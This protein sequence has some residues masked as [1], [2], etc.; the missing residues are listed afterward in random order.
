MPEPTGKS[1]RRPAGKALTTRRLLELF[2]DPADMVGSLRSQADPWLNIW[3]PCLLFPQAIGG[4]CFIGRPEGL[5]VVAGL[6]VMLL[7]VGYIHRHAPLSR[8]IGI[9]QA[10]WLLTVPWLFRQ[11]LSQDTVSVFSAWLWYVTVTMIASLVMDAYGFHLYLTT[12]N[13]TYRKDK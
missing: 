7:T 10:W 9:G 2:T 1:E 6:V 4:L 12:G 5:V 11:A 13:R 8:L 3:G